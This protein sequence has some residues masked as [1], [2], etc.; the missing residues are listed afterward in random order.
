MFQNQSTVN[1]LPLIFNLGGRICDLLQIQNPKN[2]ANFIAYGKYIR[3]RP[4]YSEWWVASC[5]L[6][7]WTLTAF[8]SFLILYTVGRT[9]WTGDQPVARPLP[10]HRIIQTHNKRTKTPMPGVGFEPTVP[11]FERAKTVHTSDSTANV[12]GASC[13]LSSEMICM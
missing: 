6:S 5:P 3:D 1:S 11:A 7:C 13:P 12:I 10:T 8:F 9:P 2:A 4:L